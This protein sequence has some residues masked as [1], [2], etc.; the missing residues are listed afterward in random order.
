MINPDFVAFCALVTIKMFM[1]KLM[2]CL[3]QSFMTEAKFTTKQ[4]SDTKVYSYEQISTVS[5]IKKLLE[6]SARCLN[7]QECWGFKHN[8]SVCTLASEVTPIIED[9]A[10]KAEDLFV[11][12]EFIKDYE[13]YGIKSSK[14]R[15]NTIQIQP[16]FLCRYCPYAQR[17]GTRKFIF[18]EPRNPRN[19]QPRH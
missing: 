8:K 4:Y 6:C 2:V 7:V 5:N 17:Q 10:T 1:A 3:L 12:Q 14:P 13:N 9:N 19:L 16:C 18:S 11:D 15:T